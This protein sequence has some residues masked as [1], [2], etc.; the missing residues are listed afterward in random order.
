M[1]KNNVAVGKQD[2]WGIENVDQ[3]QLLGKPSK[4][5]FTLWD[6]VPWVIVAMTIPI[7]IICFTAD[8]E[9]AHRMVQTFIH[10]FH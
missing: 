5:L 6:M 2:D 9:T 7:V 3:G 10:L 4:P 8:G 1:N